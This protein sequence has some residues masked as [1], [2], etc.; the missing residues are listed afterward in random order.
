MD[1]DKLIA[2]LVQCIFLALFLILGMA[3]FKGKGAFL[4]AGYNTMSP[5]ERAKYDE[6][7]LCRS[8][9]AMMFTCAGCFA[10]IILGT[11]L[12]WMALVWAG[13]G[14]MLA[15]CMGGAVLVNR[16][17]RRKGK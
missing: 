13:I 1:T 4:I 12:E 6:K 11:F 8:M 9:S 10:I 3:F 2:I 15:V 5:E 14:L 17:S 7:A 16:R